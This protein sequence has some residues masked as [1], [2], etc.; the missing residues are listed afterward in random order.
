MFVFDEKNYLPEG[1]NFEHVK[2][3]ID[4]LKKAV[5][6]DEKSHISRLFSQLVTNMKL[7]S[8]EDIGE[9]FTLVSIFKYFIKIIIIL[10]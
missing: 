9:L 6:S 4:D 2:S 10:F 3:I 5:I 1:G 8:Y 7:L